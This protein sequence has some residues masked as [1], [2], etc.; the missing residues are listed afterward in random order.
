MQAVQN[1]VHSYVH[2]SY[3]LSNFL[4]N[5]LFSYINVFKH[6]CCHFIAEKLF[7]YFE[8]LLFSFSAFFLPNRIAA[9]APPVAAD[10]VIFIKLDKYCLAM[11]DIK[12]LSLQSSRA[13]SKESTDPFSFLHLSCTSFS[14]GLQLFLWF[15]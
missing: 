10:E 4:G 7:P 3:L 1:A 6:C 14:F 5:C 12:L 2:V 11:A 13:L 15:I 8:R 9:L